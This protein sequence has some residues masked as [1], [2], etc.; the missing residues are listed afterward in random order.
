MTYSVGDIAYR[1]GAKHYL[2]VLGK[3]QDD[4]GYWHYYCFNYNEDKHVYSY[5]PRGLYIKVG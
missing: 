4:N 3:K 1:Y 2:L 5:M